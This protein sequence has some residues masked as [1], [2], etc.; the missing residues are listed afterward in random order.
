MCGRFTH[1]LTWAE[2]RDIMNLLQDDPPEG[3]DAP[4]WNIAPTQRAVVIRADRDT[5]DRRADM[6]RWGLAPRWSKDPEKGPINARVETAA[7]TPMFRDAMARRR[8]VVPASGFYEWQ[9]VTP[10]KAKAPW[11]ITPTPD[12]GRIFCFAGLWETH[13]DI[14]PTFCI[15]TT[16]PNGLMAPIHNRMPVILSPA[17]VDEWLVGEGDGE[18]V[19]FDASAPFPEQ[20]MQ[21][22][23]VSTRVN[24]PQ[25]DD[26][27]VL[28]EVV[29]ERG[30]F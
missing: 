2:L 29:E 5:H 26:P 22:R 27:S 30:L 19:R 11:S 6:F 25:I 9:V 14:G 10:G 24:K 16:A 28:E 21:A 13:P 7:T 18:C 3:F 15:L 4:R 17:Q 20:F 12:A 23:R 8:C 1:L